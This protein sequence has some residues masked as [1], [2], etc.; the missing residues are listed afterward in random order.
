MTDYT[1]S[2]ADPT[3]D[4]GITA[5]LKAYNANNPQNILKDGQAF[6]S[7]F[8]ESQ[9]NQWAIATTDANI[10]TFVDAVKAGD[11]QALQA[12]AAIAAKTP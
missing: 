8:M 2:T 9:L 11:P 10:Q 7:W 3:Q 6:L 1:V 12:V 4:A 5:Q